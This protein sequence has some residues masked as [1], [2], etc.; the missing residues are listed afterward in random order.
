MDSIP[1]QKSEP[2]GETRVKTMPAQF[3]LEGDRAVLN[4]TAEQAKVLP[5]VGK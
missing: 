1:V 2:M 3:Q 4:L 5:M